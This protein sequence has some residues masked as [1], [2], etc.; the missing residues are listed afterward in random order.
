MMPQVVIFCGGMGTRL[1]E[2]TEYKPKPM[3]TIGDKPILWHIMKYYAR[4]GFKDFVLCLGY[5]GEVIKEYFYNYE[6]LNHDFTVDFANNKKINFY[7]H[8]ESI[9]W[10]VTLVDTGADTLKGGRLKKV[11]KYIKSDNFMLTYGNGLSDVDITALYNFHIG[12]GKTGTVTGVFPLSL[13]GE[14]MVEQDRVS[15]FAE[16]P[17][18]SSGLINGGFFVFKRDIFN[19]LTDDV[20]CDFEF[21]P[22]EKLAA[23]GGLMAYRH[24]GKWQCMDTYRDTQYLNKLWKEG[25]AFWV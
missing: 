24:E 22:L 4:F 3:V 19:Y 25:K 20:N 23:A 15:L 10:T 13:F 18:V 17:Q 1:K 9:D 21:G 14:L 7:D 12:H 11:E 16:K 8:P 6:V 2:E 5:K